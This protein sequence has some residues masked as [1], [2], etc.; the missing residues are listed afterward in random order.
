MIHFI[1][2]YLV[3]ILTFE[4]FGIVIKA[5]SSDTSLAIVAAFWASCIELAILSYAD[6]ASS[7]RPAGSVVW[8]RID[9]KLLA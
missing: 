6:A 8:L 5:T 2:L 7:V 4:P 9:L 3:L 1:L